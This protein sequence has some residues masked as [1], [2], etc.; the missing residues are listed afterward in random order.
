M[1]APGPI[2]QESPRVTFLLFAYNQEATVREA[3]LAALA[4]DYANLEVVFSDDASKDG[5]FAVM[6][7]VAE[8]YRGPHTVRLNG[9]PRNLG[10]IGH[11]NEAM[12]NASGELVVGAA[13]DDVSLPERTGA[14]VAAWLASGRE[15]NSIHSSVTRID[16]EG[17][18]QGVWTP[19]ILDQPGDLDERAVSFSMVIGASHAWTRKLFE[20]FGPI[21]E[22]ETYEDLVIVFRSLLLGPLVYVDRPLV[23][24]RVG[25]GLSAAPP[26]P[27]SME[28][29]RTGLARRARLEAATLAQRSADCRRIGRAVPRALARAETFKA[30]RRDLLNGPARVLLR[31]VLHRPAGAVQV[32]RALLSVA[33]ELRRAKQRLRRNVRAT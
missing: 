4:Q 8:G 18:E 12:R 14:L 13:G 28:E 7:E 31:Q 26:P 3:C 24:Y 33:N 19:P 17:R 29:F 27:S 32:I 6:K 5:T 15:A 11:L 2:A 20:L 21:A 16:Q 23:K 30:A 22:P 25:I 10:L 9:N 1:S